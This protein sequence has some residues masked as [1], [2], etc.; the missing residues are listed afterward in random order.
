MIV[1]IWGFMFVGMVVSL[2]YQLG[3][4]KVFGPFPVTRQSNPLYY[5]FSVASNVLGIFFLIYWFEF[6]NNLFAFADWDVA[7]SIW[8]TPQATVASST[9][10]ACETADDTSYG[11][12]VNNPIRLGG[13]DVGGPSRAQEYL[14][15]L[16]SPSGAPVTFRAR[17]YI[18][19]NGSTLDFFEIKFADRRLLVYFDY[20]SYETPRAPVTFY[21]ASL[22]S[23]AGP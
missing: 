16:R 23:Y 3:T 9:A 15:N 12:D 18:L 20:F 10:D 19:Q 2:L 22:L 6:A 5:W 11:Y 13:G 4:G 1:L 8:P 7:F 17:G 21:C 14:S